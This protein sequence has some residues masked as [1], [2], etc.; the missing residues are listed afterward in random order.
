MLEK[1][2]IATKVIL[3]RIQKEKKR[4]LEKV[5]IYLENA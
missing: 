4:T 3:V 1:A 5:S 2:K